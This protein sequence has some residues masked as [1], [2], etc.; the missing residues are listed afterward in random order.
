MGSLSIEFLEAGMVLA[1]D[2]RDASGMVL[3][4]AGAEI[5]ARHIQIFKSW[6]IGE[7]E[8]KGADQAAVNA[9]I[10]ASLDAVERARIEKEIDRLFI[11]NDPSDPVVEELRRIALTR[12]SLRVVAAR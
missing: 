5:N 12:E 4:G 6:G 7:V 8:I 10:L 9:Q 1:R 2:V 3:L 11:H